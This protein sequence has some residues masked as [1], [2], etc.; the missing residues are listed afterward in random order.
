MTRERMIQYRNIVGTQ[1]R[2]IIPLQIYTNSMITHRIGS[3][4]RPRPRLRP[5]PHHR[6]LREPRR[7]GQATL[8]L[9]DSQSR[10][11]PRRNRTYNKNRSRYN[12]WVNNKGWWGTT[13]DNRMPP[14]GTVGEPRRIPST[15]ANMVSN[16]RR[17]QRCRNPLK[18]RGIK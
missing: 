2:N 17:N 12:S 9:T 3:R 1:S 11:H 13:A 15:N 4:E 10:T 18:G 14:R 7:L 5:Q 8:T 16:R 6:R